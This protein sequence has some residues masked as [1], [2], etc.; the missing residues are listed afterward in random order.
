MRYEIL[1]F[2]ADDTPA[3]PMSFIC[4]TDEDAVSIAQ[5]LLSPGQF[6]EVRCDGLLIASVMASVAGA[7]T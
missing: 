4:D 6:A 7:D 5:M 2:A 3:E 1:I